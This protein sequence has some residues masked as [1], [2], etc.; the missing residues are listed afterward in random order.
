METIT[1]NTNT[2]AIGKPHGETFSNLW[3]MAWDLRKYEFM[4]RFDVEYFEHGVQW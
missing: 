1:N 2:K 3:W 4:V